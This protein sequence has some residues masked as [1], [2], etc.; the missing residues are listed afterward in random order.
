MR[1]KEARPL[2]LASQPSIH[3]ISAVA[4]HAAGARLNLREERQLSLAPQPEERRAGHVEEIRSE[5]LRDCVDAV[6]AAVRLLRWR[7][8]R[9]ERTLR[10]HA[11]LPVTKARTDT[12]VCSSMSNAR[13]TDGLR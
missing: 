7:R 8:R 6:R 1:T 2:P 10:S 9:L 4:D 13:S 11:A 12:P 3:Q 5:E